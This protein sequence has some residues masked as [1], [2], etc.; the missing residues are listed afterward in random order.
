MGISA[1]ALTAVFVAVFVS[2]FAL[3]VLRR[4]K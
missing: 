2:L 1:G 4:R 3:L